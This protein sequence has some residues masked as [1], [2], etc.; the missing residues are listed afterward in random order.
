LAGLKIY[1]DENVDIRIAEGLRRRGTEAFSAIGKGM[2]GITDAEHFQYASKNKAV[3]FT[4]DHHFLE[5]AKK[6]TKEGKE[7]WGVIYVEMN[8]LSIGE[9]IKRLALYADI[10]S[11]EEMKNQI[12]F[13]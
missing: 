2:I 3:I 9:C 12:E 13:L 10:L 11:P 8:K 4:H 1:T 7:H 5:I 6:I